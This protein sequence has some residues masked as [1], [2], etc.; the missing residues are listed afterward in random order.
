MSSTEPFPDLSPRTP[1]SYRDYIEGLP[2]LESETTQLGRGRASFES[3]HL[4]GRDFVLARLKLGP[5]TSVFL[6][7]D[8]EWLTL[9]APVRWRGDYLFNGLRARPYDI[10]LSSS[11]NGFANIAADRDNIGIGLRKSRLRAACAALSGLPVEEI[12][13]GD[14][15]LSLGPVG[16]ARLHNR[17]ASLI[18]ASANA[19]LGPGRFALGDALE[20]DV[21]CDIA[22]MLLPFVIRRA[23]R[24]PTNLDALRV[25]RRSVRMME[26][27]GSGAPSIADLC[28][29]NGVS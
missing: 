4:R 7:A 27:R 14:A 12:A 17:L 23:P 1:L 20:G 6:R 21:I 24:T 15:R 13:F 22:A 26:A 28:E 8:P 25:V 19:P 2:V 3:L 18:A 11:A 9:V 29:A 10:F 5:Q 16:G